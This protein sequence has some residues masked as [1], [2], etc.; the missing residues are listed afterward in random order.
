MLSEWMR[1]RRICNSLLAD[2]LSPLLTHT[3]LL[4]SCCIINLSSSHDWNRYVP[5]AHTYVCV[6]LFLCFPCSVLQWRNSCSSFKT[7]LIGHLLALDPQFP[8]FSARL[9]CSLTSLIR[10]LCTSL[11]YNITR[12][13]SNCGSAVCLVWLLHLCDCCS[14][15]L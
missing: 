7:L 6:V 9:T 11:Y 15:Q 14:T 12:C 8:F 4:P 2:S 1:W 10:G 5:Y 13:Y 3:L